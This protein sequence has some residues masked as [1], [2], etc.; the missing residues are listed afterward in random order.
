[1]R[2][3][4]TGQVRFYGA[5]FTGGKEGICSESA[6]NVETGRTVFVTTEGTRRK[7]GVGSIKGEL[8]CD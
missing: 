8:N 4:V 7:L 2:F 1:M 3:F 5:R 6:T